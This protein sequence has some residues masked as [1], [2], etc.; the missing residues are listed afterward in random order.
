MLGN[1]KLEVTAPFCRIVAVCF[2]QV[3][4]VL[5]DCIV[6]LCFDVLC[7]TRDSR[8]FLFWVRV[9]ADIL[10]EICGLPSLF[11]F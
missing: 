11:L 5:F 9:G 7:L 3:R 1:N 8:R 10:I 4:T 6:V 2:T